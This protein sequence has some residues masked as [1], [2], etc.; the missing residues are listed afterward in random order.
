MDCMEGYMRLIGAGVLAAALFASK[1]FAQ[2]DACL[3]NF[4]ESGSILRGKVLETFEEFPGID[5]ATAIRRLK[6]QLP[7]IGMSVIAVDAAAGTIKAENQAPNSRPFPVEFTVSSIPGGA[8]VRVLVKMKAG[9]MVVGGTK[10]GI[11]DT[12]RLVKHESDPKTQTVTPAESKKAEPP[13]S[14]QDV[15]KL[16]A[17]GIDD[18]VIITKIRLAPNAAFD[19]STDGLVALKKSGASKAVISAMVTRGSEGSSRTPAPAQA[20]ET[21]PSL[22][23]VCPGEGGCMFTTWAPRE[24]LTLYGEPR[25]SA[26][27]VGRLAKHERVTGVSSL[28][29]PSKPGSCTVRRTVTATDQKTNRDVRLTP[30]TVLRTIYYQGEGFMLASVNGSMVSVGGMGEE[31]E[32]GVEPVYELWLQVRTKAGLSGWTNKREALIGTSRYDEELPPVREAVNK[33]PV[34][35]GVAP[36]FGLVE[37]SEGQTCV[38]LSTEAQK[39]QR[40][41]MLMFDPPAVAFGTV[42]TRLTKPCGRS[43]GRAYWILPDASVPSGTGVGVIAP[44]F[45]ASGAKPHPFVTVQGGKYTARRCTSNEGANFTAWRGD[46]RVWRGYIALGYET[47]PDCTAEETRP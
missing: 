27:S 3:A 21:F 37:A 42:Q 4:Q 25:A 16:V 5:Q 11:C 32:C 44:K 2:T 35:A 8:R 28:L 43:T 36:P 13:F 22:P 24:A 34:A 39:G 20:S 45:E 7:A 33:P 15:L 18:E 31:L 23:N 30:G 47:V 9:Q 46:T 1:G 40:I 26:T 19:V 17:A 6:T 41:A 12:V 29:V 38:T 14:N 10:P